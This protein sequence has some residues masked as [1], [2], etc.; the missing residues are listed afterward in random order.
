MVEGLGL[1]VWGLG[2][3]V[4][5]VSFGA[6][7]PAVVEHKAGYRVE[8]SCVVWGGG[9]SFILSGWWSLGLG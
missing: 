6:D 5:D 4:S 2:S 1:R 7:L 8:H 3:R 9:F